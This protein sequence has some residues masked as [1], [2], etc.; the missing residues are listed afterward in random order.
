MVSYQKQN[1]VNEVIYDDV[2]QVNLADGS[3]KKITGGLVGTNHIVPMN[4]GLLLISLDVKVN[5]DQLLPYFYSF[6]DE[7]TIQLKLPTDNTVKNISF[8]IY[9]NKIALSSH[10]QPDYYQLLLNQLNVELIAPEN[11]LMV[12]DDIFEEPKDL[13]TTQEKKSTNTFFH[14][15]VDLLYK[16]DIYGTKRKTH[17]WKE[18]GL[19]EE[20][21]SEFSVK[22]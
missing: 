9:T 6:S 20:S 21:S 16:E 7:S 18:Y 15:T 2:Y 13:V 11:R 4:D 12:Y 3:E 14:A 1:T 17:R 5:N 19:I 22:Y 8:N 10:N